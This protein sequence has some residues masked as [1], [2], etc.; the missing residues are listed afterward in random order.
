MANALPQGTTLI[1]RTSV[2]PSIY[3]IRIG[4]VDRLTDVTYAAVDDTTGVGT[5][6]AGTGERFFYTATR[7][8]AN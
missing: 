3:S 4:W 7:R 5:N 6:T 1:E 2:A 8:F